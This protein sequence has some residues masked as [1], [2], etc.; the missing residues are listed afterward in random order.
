M[1]DPGESGRRRPKPVHVHYFPKRTPRGKRPLTEISATRTVEFQPF[2]GAEELPTEPG[3]PRPVEVS[4][5]KKPKR[6]AKA[7]KGSRKRRGK[8]GG[9][10][11]E[12]EPVGPG[13]HLQQLRALLERGSPGRQAAELSAQAVA[14]LSLFGHQLFEAGR[15]AEA[16]LL[17]EG[18]VALGTEEAFA[19]TML[20][21]I[22]LSMAQHERALALFEAAIQLDGEDLAARVYRAEIRI[23]QNRLLHA[24]E[25]L[26]QAL[27]LGGEDDPFIQ[28]ALRLKGIALERA[29]K[30]G[31]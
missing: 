19:Y 2:L 25:E 3:L 31:R 6:K 27:A 8:G 30:A 18:L 15:L 13:H 12:V 23:H 16:R 29:R 26:D 21:T 20:G 11:A 24:L 10:A 17:F 4:G 28:R 7:A 1:P 5:P 14:E 22:Y 9:R